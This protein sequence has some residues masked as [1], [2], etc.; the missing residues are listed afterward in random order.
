MEHVRAVAKKFMDFLEARQPLEA[1]GMLGETGRFIV[2][3]NTPISGVY[4]GKTA[5]L[6]L[7]T[8][9][10]STLPASAAPRMKFSETIVEGNRVVMLAS[11]EGE[12]PGGTPYIQPYFCYVGRVEG[13][14]FSEIIEF[15]DTVMVETALFGKKLIPG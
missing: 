8:P 12:G 15:N 3:G 5:F 14:G 7:V 13:D 4:E 6:A 1:I 11:G 10:L 9:V 2:I